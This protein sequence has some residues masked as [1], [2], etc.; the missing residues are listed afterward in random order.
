MSG[1]RGGL[2][3]NSGKMPISRYKKKTMAREDSLDTAIN[4]YTNSEHACLSQNMLT[5]QRAQTDIT[6][7]STG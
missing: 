2:C 6:I 3:A 4:R 1:S 5:Q 7:G